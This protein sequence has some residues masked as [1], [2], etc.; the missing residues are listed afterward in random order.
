[1]KKIIPAWL[2]MIL[3]LLGVVIP[4]VIAIMEWSTYDLTIEWVSTDNLVSDT[5]Q[6]SELQVFV[7]K[8]LVEDPKLLK[9]Q[10]KNTGSE[11]IKKAHF[12]IPL[13]LE[14]DSGVSL[15]KASISSTIPHSIP[16][17]VAL[18][19][20]TLEL[21]PL[22]LNAKDTLNISIITSGD[23]E[24]L[25][26]LGRIE[27]IQKLELIK[28]ENGEEEI[29]KKGVWV[30]VCIFLFFIYLYF[31]ASLVNLR[32]VVIPK[33]L[34]GSCALSAAVAIG[35]LGRQ[36][37]ISYKSHEYFLLICLGVFTLVVVIGYFLFFS[38]KR[39]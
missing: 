38:L 10:I 7:G 8:K 13:Q 15:L 20:H 34:S 23:V 28:R 30:V 33:W 29:Y 16:A 32:T 26:V 1:M 9:I 4:V 25:A 37:L 11:A 27:N 19:E 2:G 14:F 5:G 31:W 36:I 12:D 21:Q 35:G 3:A 39:R 18:D 17:K 22:L 24:H 6:D